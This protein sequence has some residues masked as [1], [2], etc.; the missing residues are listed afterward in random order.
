MR[1]TPDRSESGDESLPFWSVSRSFE[2]ERFSLY[3][4]LLTRPVREEGI[5]R[6]RQSVQQWLRDEEV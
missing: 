5:L 3:C 4:A 6:L 2:Q 1:F